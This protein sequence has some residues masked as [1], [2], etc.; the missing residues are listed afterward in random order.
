QKMQTGEF[1]ALPGAKQLVQKLAKRY[2]LAICSGAL[3]EEIETML[4]GI[5]L[6]SCFKV[7]VSAEDVTIGKPDPSG[8]LQTTRLLAEMTQQP[9]TPA[10][11]LIIEDAPSVMQNVARVGFKVLG[12]ATTYPLEQLEGAHWR[13]PSLEPQV[14]TQQIPTLKP[15]LG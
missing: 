10:D 1:S 15:V 3:R 4:T 14:V 6:R 8:Y 5:G 2:P 13:V 9:L 12:V 7:I 11:C